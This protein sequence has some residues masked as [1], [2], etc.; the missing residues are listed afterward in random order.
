MHLGLV[1]TLF[2]AP[3][4]FAA[5]LL[6]PDLFAW[7]SQSPP[8][9]MHDGSMDLTTIRN[10]VLYRFS[11]PIPNIGAGPLELREV[12]HPDLTQDIYQRIYDTEG[13][14]SEVFLGS[15]P[16]A[17]PPYGHLYL[18]GIAEY[19]LRTVTSG[20]G[21]GPIVAT[22]VKTSYALIDGV[23]YNT[24]LPGTQPRT[25][26]DSIHDPLLGISVG[27]ADVYRWAVP[28]Q[29]I[30]V[31]GL[32]DGQYWLEVE[33]DPDELIQETNDANNTTRVLVDLVVPDPMIMPGDYNQDNVVDAADYIVW[34]KTLGQDV[35]AE[36]APTATATAQS[37]R[38]TSMYGGR[39]SA[40]PL[41]AAAHLRLQFPSRARS[42]GPCS[43]FASSLKCADGNEFLR[44]VV[45]ATGS[46]Q[47][48]T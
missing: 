14:I 40:R 18:K 24:S 35:T 19:R 23:Q 9:Y 20:S 36:T 21:V 42:V 32:P 43:L 46:K 15:F 44:F 33:I 16:D 7:E 27:W 34:R 10:K 28:G 30:D 17:D 48:A 5:E 31:T 1:A 4:G 41:P 37:N 22:R 13:G 8:Y 6:L 25:V 11:L 26:Y 38:P 39:S 29:W 45:A 3:A 2:A 47:R 12:T